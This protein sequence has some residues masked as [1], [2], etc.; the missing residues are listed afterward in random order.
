MNK[1]IVKKIK[2]IGGILSFTGIFFLAFSIDL[3]SVPTDLKTIG[4][5]VFLTISVIYSFAIILLSCA[6][7]SYLP[8]D[9]VKKTRKLILN[10]T[11]AKSVLTKYIPSGVF[12]YAS[13]QIDL[14][15]HGFSQKE[16]AKSSISEIISQ[17]A[18]A[19]L[20][21]GSGLIISGEPIQA[22]RIQETLLNFL[23]FLFIALGI[24]CIGGIYFLNRNLYV[25]KALIL[26]IIFFTITNSTSTYIT[27]LLI[28]QP[29]P[30]IFL[31]SILTLSWLA[32]FIVIGASGG[33]GIRE[34]S[35]LFLLSNYCPPETAASI[36]LLLRLIATFA[37]TSFFLVST[38][39]A[40]AFK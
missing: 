36:A 11:Y 20:I 16:I 6:W 9:Q 40:R 3:S 32:G 24:G 18:A 26:H 23:P 14:I 10:N 2:I 34:A 5:P 19:S 27:S 33:I 31:V 38:A 4:L 28:E 15:E 30:Y 12:Q 22:I 21:I 8:R 39:I 35:I 29:V 13:R 25:S 7:I 17:V 1:D 37:D